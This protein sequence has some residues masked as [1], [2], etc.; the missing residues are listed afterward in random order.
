MM[1][2]QIRRDRETKRQIWRKPDGRERPSDNFRRWRPMKADRRRKR[3]RRFKSETANR[4]Q[5]KKEA[6]N[7]N[8]SDAGNEI[9]QKS[10]P[11]DS[12]SS[13]GDASRS[14]PQ[15]QWRRRDLGD[16]RDPAA[17]R[18]QDLCDA[19]ARE[20]WRWWHRLVDLT[21][22]AAVV[23]ETLAPDLGEWQVW[24]RRR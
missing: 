21:A 12:T 7:S 10:G 18:L 2:R 16:A 13:S 14:E 22:E 3:L 8:R 24:R 9:G 20:V 5:K 23:E 15:P 4:R 11:G 6:E 17:K 1:E 19:A